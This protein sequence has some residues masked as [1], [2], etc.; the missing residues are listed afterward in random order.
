M[1]QI[2]SQLLFLGEQDLA[3]VV[4]VFESRSVRGDAGGID[5]RTK[6]IPHGAIVLEGLFRYISSG[7][8]DFMCIDVTSG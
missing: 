4:D 3:E 5:P 2:A 7:L 6:L 1:H 8:V